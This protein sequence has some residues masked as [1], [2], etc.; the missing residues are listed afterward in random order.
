M[1]LV[2]TS[3]STWCA[4]IYVHRIKSQIIE[5]SK[6]FYEEVYR[7]CKNDNKKLTNKFCD[8]KL[9]LDLK[10]SFISEIQNEFKRAKKH[11]DVA[12]QTVIS[13]SDNYK[14][15]IRYS[16]SDPGRD[17][18]LNNYE[19]ILKGEE[20]RTIADVIKLR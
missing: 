8:Q 15:Q 1:Q 9:K 20:Y 16:F 3:R 12:Y 5:D 11:Y 17:S 2:V 6:N 4:F 18:L 7:R 19:V 13:L 14:E 10:E